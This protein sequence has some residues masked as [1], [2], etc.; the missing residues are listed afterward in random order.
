MSNTI[1]PI[2]VAPAAITRMYGELMLKDVAADKA[3]RFAAPGGVTVVSN[4]PVFV[5]GHL[6]GYNRRILAMCNQPE[7]TAAVPAEWDAL[8]K[9]GVECKDDASGKLYPSLAVV[10]KAFFD[11]LD[12][13][14]AAVKAADDATLTLPN[15]GEGRMKELFPLRSQVIAFLLS[16]HPMSHFG[17]V[18]AWRRMQGLPSAM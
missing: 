15:P 5:Y 7:G 16:G 3:A 17:Q 6:A 13:A 1:G 11:G 14:V 8:F 2:L 4:H 9:A 12:A 10:T 18:S